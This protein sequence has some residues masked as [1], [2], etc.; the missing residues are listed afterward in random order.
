M[1]T[2][3][4]S[5]ARPHKPI[6]ATVIARIVK[7]AEAFAGVDGC[8]E[9]PFSRNVRSGY[10]QLTA[11]VD[12]KH[13]T[14]TAHRASFAAFNGALIP[15]RLVCHTC[16]NKGCFNP[17]H[18]YQ[19]TDSDNMQDMWDRAP[20]DRSARAARGERHGSRTKPERIQRGTVHHASKLTD[21]IVREIRASN[22]SEAKMAKK[23]GVS[24]S[25]IR[26]AKIGET[27]T[28]VK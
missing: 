1:A 23:Y 20:I 5:T 11:F 12:G 27:W 9:W 18:L 6:P 2:R 14:Y 16:D 28:H 26:S 22:L 24:S 21:E 19:G 13:K 25:T 3:I 17:S 15:G 10:G 4:L 7:A 8:W